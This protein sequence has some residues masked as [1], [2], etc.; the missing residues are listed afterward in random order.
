MGEESIVNLVIAVI[1]TVGGVMAKHFSDRW[2]EARGRRLDEAQRIAEQRD[3]SIK[4][5]DAARDEVGRLRRCK[6]EWEAAF[7]RLRIAAI[8]H[9]VPDEEIPRAPDQ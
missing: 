1:G 4:D 5:R 3:K 7:H 6:Q 8:R 2:K 9:H